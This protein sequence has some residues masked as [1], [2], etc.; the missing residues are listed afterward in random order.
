MCR[1]KDG[2]VFVDGVAAGDVVRVVDDGRRGGAGRARL[3]SIVQASD[4]RR[5]DADVQADCKVVDRCGGCDWLH[6][7]SSARHRWKSAIVTDALRRVGRFDEGLLHEVVR[8][9]RAG[10]DDDRVQTGRRRV[11]LT[12]GP[13]GQPTF[14][15]ARSHER[16]VI[17]ACRSLHPRLERAVE[18][19]PLAGLPVGLEV[20]LAVDDTDRVVAAIDDVASA[21]RLVDDGVVSGVVVAHR[22][23]SVTTIGD[24]WLVGEITAGRFAA[25]SDA[26]CFAQ[27]TRFGGDAIVQ[28]VLDGIDDVLDG[29]TVLEL[30]CGAGHV[31]LPLAVRAARVVAIEGDARA[32]EF[33]ADNRRLVDRGEHTIEP[34]V[35]F[36]DATL[37]VPPA[38]IVVMDPPRTG[39][40]DGRAIAAS[41]AAMRVRRLV[42]VSCDPATGARDLR[43][44]VDAGFRLTHLVPIDAF[45]RTH[46]VE[47]VA[48][49]TLGEAA[50]GAVKT[51]G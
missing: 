3:V 20:R 28:A 37:A 31:S 19:L 32:I 41:L 29:A 50:T 9:L 15:A 45:P 51:V 47:W 39:L 26:A 24:P 23:G 5:A 21:R 1:S 2:V 25:R 35:R 36:I 13:H 48:M 11:R 46:H 12:I 17:D 14:S 34:L 40:V 7:T 18:A 6:L 16:V 33:L 4:E 10:D 43:A 42:M 22:G 8:P 44:A 27:A 38:D 49:L 30:F